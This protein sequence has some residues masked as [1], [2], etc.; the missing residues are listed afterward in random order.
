MKKITSASLALLTAVFFFGGCDTRPLG[1]GGQQPT[2]TVQNPQTNVTVAE[3]VN[4][5]SPYLN[6]KIQIEALVKSEKNDCYLQDGTNQIKIECWA[7]RSVASCAPSVEK[8]TPPPSMSNYFDKKVKLTGI[9]E[10]LEKEEYINK[11]WIV[12]GSYYM[13]T[14]VENAVIID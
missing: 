2:S 12:T 11:Q 4:N 6:K 3:L 5:P 14:N 9:L 8:C 1:F 13:I 10:K 7:P